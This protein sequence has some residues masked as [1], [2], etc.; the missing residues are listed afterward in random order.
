LRPP[1]N[2]AET[3]PRFLLVTAVSQHLL[4]TL[5]PIIGDLLASSRENS[6]VSS[7]PRPAPQI[8][9]LFSYN[10][11]RTAVAQN[12]KFRNKLYGIKKRFE[13]LKNEVMFALIP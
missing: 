3:T 13:R 2:Q 8:Q 12:S 4:T 10:K 7:T 6:N 1:P 5:Q 9:T 11:Q